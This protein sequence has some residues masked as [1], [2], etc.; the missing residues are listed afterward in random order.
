VSPSE[1]A[2]PRVGITNP[3]HDEEP[4]VSVDLVSEPR[5]PHSGPT[6]ARGTVWA[7][8][9]AAIAADEEARQ[10]HAETPRLRDAA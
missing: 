7:D 6:L 5:Q 10:R 1:A 9:L 2:P 8:I 3:W 4:V